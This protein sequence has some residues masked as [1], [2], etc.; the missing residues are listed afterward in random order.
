MKLTVRPLTP[1]RW[2]D[3]ETIFNAKGCSVARGCWCMYYRRS[4]SA[5]EVPPGTTQAQANRAALKALVASGNPPGLI[6]YDGKVPVG[7]VSLGPRHDYAKLRRS[8]VMKAVDDQPVWSIVCYVVPAEF[9]GRG[10][11]RSLLDAAIVYARKHGATL[12]EAYPVD[13]PERASDDA[14][15]FGAKSMYDAAGFDEVARRKPTRPI[16]RLRTT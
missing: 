11:A 2:P 12:L 7:W 8:P 3:L 5:G 15:W 6:G 13:R 14:M 10:V 9:R 4:G 1:A 16:V